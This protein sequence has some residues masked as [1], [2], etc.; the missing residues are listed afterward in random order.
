MEVLTLEISDS[1]NDCML[2]SR[3][4]REK[5][6]HELQDAVLDFPKEGDNYN[7]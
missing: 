2:D 1:V 6:L 3:V 5:E 7:C 4:N